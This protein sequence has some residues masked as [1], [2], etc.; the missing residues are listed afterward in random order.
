MAAFASKSLLGH[1]R[2]GRAD[3]RSGHVGF[4]PI[5][6]KFCLAEK[7][8]DVPE[9]DIRSH[10]AQIS[11]GWER[12]LRVIATARTKTARRSS[13]RAAFVAAP[14]EWTVQP[15]AHYR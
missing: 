8:H 15:H 3:C 11:L 13:K 12:R 7:F 6:I 1:S 4:R 10:G 14:S 2:L 9:P 5:V